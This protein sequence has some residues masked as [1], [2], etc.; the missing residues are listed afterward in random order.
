MELKVIDTLEPNKLY[1]GGCLGTWK[2]W[3]VDD[4][5]YTTLPP[6][7]GSSF[8]MTN[9][10]ADPTWKRQGYFYRAITKPYFMH[11]KNGIVVDYNGV[12]VGI[13]S[14]LTDDDMAWLA[15]PEAAAMIK[16]GGLYAEVKAMSVNSQNSLRH[17]CLVQLR[18]DYDGPAQK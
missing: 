5:M 9:G 15:T 1:E 2:Y 6:Q 7:M 13:S 17:P 18:P 11:W 10:G 8:H 12:K 16:A 14:G 4:I 3:E